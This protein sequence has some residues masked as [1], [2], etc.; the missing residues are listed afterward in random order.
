MNIK[1]HTHQLDMSDPLRAYAERH[2]AESISHFFK[3]QAARLDIEFEDA[4][5]GREKRCQVTVWVPHGKTLVASAEDANP[6]AAVDLA[7]EK[8]SRELRRYK[9]KRLHTSRY[10]N[11]SPASMPAAASEAVEE[12]ETEDFTDADFKSD[13]VARWEEELKNR[14]S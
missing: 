11:T 4:V 13:D 1:I 14:P 3:E 10:G 12:E 2:I 9:E 6:Y 5:G 8:I 7:A